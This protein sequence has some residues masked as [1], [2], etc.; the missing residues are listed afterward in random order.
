MSRNWI[1]LPYL[2]N[3]KRNGHFKGHPQVYIGP[4]FLFSLHLVSVTNRRS[5]V[6]CDRNQW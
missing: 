3:I 6:D 1:G 4:F 5:L 2:D